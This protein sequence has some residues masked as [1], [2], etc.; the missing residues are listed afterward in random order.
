M[1]KAATLKRCI[2]CDAPRRRDADAFILRRG[3]VCFALLNLY[4]YNNGHLMVAPLRHAGT[5]AAFTDAERLELFDIAVDMQARL[6]RALRPDGFNFGVNLGRSAGAGVL[7]HLH[8]HIVPRWNG[9]TNFM[10]VVGK[11]KVLPMSLEAVYKLLRRK[12]R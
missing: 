1:K 3:R 4:P 9:D 2:F 12:K 11:T 8:L 5:L 10:T 6:E 7:G